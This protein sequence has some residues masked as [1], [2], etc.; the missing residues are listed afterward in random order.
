MQALVSVWE[1]RPDFSGMS[2]T[3][4]VSRGVNPQSNHCLYPKTTGLVLHCSPL[5]C[6]F[7]SWKKLVNG[8]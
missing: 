4:A 7:Y 8:H 6:I 2:I 5:V 3:K 1:Q